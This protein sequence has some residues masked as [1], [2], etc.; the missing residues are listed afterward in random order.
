MKHTFKALATAGLLAASALVLQ[1]QPYY[2]VGDVVNGWASPSAIQMNGGPTV[3]NYSV[4][5]GTAGNYEQLKVTAGSWG[6]TWPGNNLVVRLDSTG[7]NTIY[8]YPAA[9]NDGWQPLQDRVGFADPG[10]MSFEIAG[11]FT[12]PNWGSDPSAQLTLQGNG[13]YTNTYVIATPGTHN[14]KFRTPGTWS[15]FNGGSDFGGGNNATVTT[16]NA[17]QAVLFQLDLPNGRWLAGS[18]APPPVT[19]TVVFAVDMTYQIELGLFTPGSSVFVAGAFNGWPGTGAGAL[20]LNN[21]PAY[22]GGSNTNIYYGTNIFVGV[23]STAA[24]QF[25][26]TQNDPS[27]Q[28]GG[29]ETS[30][31]RTVTLLSSNGTINLPVGVFSDLYPAEVLSAPAAVTFSVDMANAVGTDSHH[32]DPTVDTV[33]L[34]GAFAG[35][36]AWAGGA[37][38][39]PAPPGFQMTEVGVSTVYTNT[40][41]LPAGTPLDFLYKFGMD[42]GGVNGGP[43]DDE[44]AVGANHV[45]V[46]RSTAE[47]PYAL[48]TDAF[49]NMYGEPYFSA[50]SLSGGNLKVGAPSGGN[51]SVS[52][53]GRPGAHLQVNTN[54]NGGTWQDLPS[55]DGGSW[56]AGYNSTNGLVSVTNWPSAGKAFFRLVKP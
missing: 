10:N 54:L 28:N 6:T 15:D 48:P 23:P 36:Y 1:A 24:T 34:N 52:W 42:P 12:S 9:P 13:V 5:G 22:Q 19:N 16:T 8:F 2:I 45:R 41:T 55:T 50:G 40:V 53:L 49:G 31:N 20:Q 30:G 27:A 11:D 29:W 32:F 51:V 35:W 17:N 26:Y 18:L 37:N 39:S 44:A 47:N 25:K 43:L 3:Y 38:P 14:F 46:V 4:T 7:G 56:T 21:T 33:Y